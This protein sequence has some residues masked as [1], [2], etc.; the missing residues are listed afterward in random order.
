MKTDKHE[1][2]AAAKRQHELTPG[3]VSHSPAEREVKTEPER[4]RTH[5]GKDKSK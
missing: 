1:H 5:G 4:A 2:K 3:R